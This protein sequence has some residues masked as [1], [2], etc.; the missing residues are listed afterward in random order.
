M[1]AWQRVSQTS[2]ARN[3]IPD[4]SNSY[5][6]PPFQ[7]KLEQVGKAEIPEL[8][9]A[10]DPSFG[11]VV[12]NQRAGQSPIRKEK[13][14]NLTEAA[15]PVPSGAKMRSR[16]IDIGKILNTRRTFVQVAVEHPRA[17]LNGMIWNPPIGADG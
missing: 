3:T 11:W 16:V 6:A 13:S 17:C 9:R 4:S 15:G 8:H 12:P 1:T 2:N 7:E 10:K 14:T 5:L